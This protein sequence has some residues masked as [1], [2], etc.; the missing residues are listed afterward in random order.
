[1]GLT[2]IEG[3]EQ[4]LNPVPGKGRT[5]RGQVVDWLLRLDE[6]P[7]DMALRAQFDA[8][9]DRSE[10]HRSAYEAMRDVWTKAEGLPSGLADATPA[11]A[12]TRPPWS[13]WRRGG[14]VALAALA[15]CM[16]VV[17][18]PVIQ[19]RLSADYRT[20]VAELQH[21]VLEDGSRV[22]LDAASALTIDFTAGRREVRILA[23]RAFFQ[24]VSSVQ[25]PFV[26]VAS[27]VE[28]TVTG[29]SFS[30]GATSKDVAVEVETGS[31]KV[32]RNGQDVAALTVGQT[33]RVSFAG[34]VDRGTLD[35]ED[36]ASWRDHRLVVAG[37]TVRSVVEEIGRH[38]SGVIV[39][40]DQA[41]ADRLVTGVIDLKRPSEALHAVVNVRNGK[42]LEVQPYLT[43][44]SSR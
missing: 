4:V 35:P 27:D 20:D 38:V 33:M 19:L 9:L 23:G 8:W 12:A 34:V 43:V 42:V 25:R 30:V 26:V 31:V 41:I 44:I 1:M 29:T 10:R 13:A 16:M 32:S 40:A 37:A 2:R 39:F 36:V 17:A 18:I 3:E 7:D 22:T 6:A 28:V 14:Y 5:L 11:A 21:V 24:V 15:A